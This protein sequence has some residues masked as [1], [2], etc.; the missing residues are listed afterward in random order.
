VVE[1]DGAVRPGAGETHLCIRPGHRFRLVDA[2]MTNFHLPRSSLL[3][4]V[5]AF[6]GRERLLAA[7]G[8]A[9]ARGYRFYSYG[10]AMLVD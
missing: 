3:L 7:Y 5:A 1:A 4:L 9:I 8:E 6:A 2:L 10:D